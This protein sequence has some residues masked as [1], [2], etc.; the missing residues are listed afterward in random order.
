[1]SPI[2]K[3]SNVSTWIRCLVMSLGIGL[4]NLSLP[5][6]AANT[7]NEIVVF[8]C[9]TIRSPDRSFWSPGVDVDVEHSM[10]ASCYLIRHKDGLMVWDTGLPAFVASKPEGVSIRGG[11]I[12]LFLDKPFPQ[13]LQDFGTSLDE[14]DHLALS[15]M[16]ADHSGNASAFSNATWYVQ[17]AEYDAAFGPLAKKLGFNIN[18]YS[19]LKH[20]KTVKLNGHH[21]VYGDGSVVI[22][23][24]PGHTPGHQVLF[25]RFT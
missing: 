23:S 7:A 10:V 12:E 3:V 9:G 22:I 21:D 13:L 11:K 2:T 8:E 18:I 15:H 6:M 20:S 17:E 19:E 16:H 1:M 5:V 14:I 4:T 24:A 25:V